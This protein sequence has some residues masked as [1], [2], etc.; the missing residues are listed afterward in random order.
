MNKKLPIISVIV[1]ISGLIAQPVAAVCPICT[2]A[3]ASGVGLSRYLGID[4]I[5]TGL[6]I[7]G[8][9]VSMIIWTLSW[10]SKKKIHFRWQAII[11]IAYIA[12]II[13]PLYFYGLLSNPG[14]NSCVCGVNKLLLGII[15]GAV[16]FWAGAEWYSYLKKK[17][18]DHA[19]FHF[20]KV[21]MPLTPLIIL[22]FIFYWLIK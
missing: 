21:V 15:N 8:L 11:T 13:I 14:N 18:H 20:Q 17:N 16:G 2:I 3:V 10:L 4:D 9:T 19:Y 7:G 22:S 1:F 6:W 12:I 5:I